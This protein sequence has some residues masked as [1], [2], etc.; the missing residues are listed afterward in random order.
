MEWENRLF[1]FRRISGIS[2]IFRHTTFNLAKFILIL[3]SHFSI[4]NFRTWFYNIA[5]L[6]LGQVYKLFTWKQSRTGPSN[7]F[8]DISAG[9]KMQPYRWSPKANNWRKSLGT[10]WWYRSLISEANYLKHVACT[11]LFHKPSWTPLD[12]YVWL[13]SLKW[14]FNMFLSDL[15][16]KDCRFKT[17][18]KN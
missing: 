16:N 4:W 14:K 3:K 6:Y 2:Q 15:A 7:F 17:I 5:F 10:F 8:G 1:S 11:F 9:D 12:D 13:K 18:N